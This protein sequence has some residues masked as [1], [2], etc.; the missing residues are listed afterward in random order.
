M[1]SGGGGGGVCACNEFHSCA[2]RAQIAFL[3]LFL[4]LAWGGPHVQRFAPFVYRLIYLKCT[5]EFIFEFVFGAIKIARYI[6]NMQMRA[7]I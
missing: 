2:H 6:I 1:V 3:A 7:N 5:L 4:L